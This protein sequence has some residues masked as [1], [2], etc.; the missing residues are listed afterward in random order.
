MERG[1]H[2]HPNY[3]GYEIFKTSMDGILGKSANKKSVVVVDTSALI[4][5]PML[6]PR[7]LKQN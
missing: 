7:Y 1:N 2:P 4:K 5:R 6:K 3:T